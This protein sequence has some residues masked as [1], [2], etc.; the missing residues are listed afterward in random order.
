MTNKEAATIL[1]NYFKP[2]IIRNDS[3]SVAHLL[4]L[5]AIDLA[6]EALEAE[7]T[8]RGRW[9]GIDDFPHETWECSRCGKII[10]TDKPPHYCENC[11]KRMD[12]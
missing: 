7:P 1:I 5:E 2:P 8:E 4:A 11:G 9:I 6:V 10:E 3:K 12:K